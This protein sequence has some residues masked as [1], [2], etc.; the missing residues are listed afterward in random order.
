MS[1][2]QYYEFQALD[3]PLDTDAQ[4]A[5]RAISSRAQITSHS[6]VN[7]YHWGDFKGDPL[8]LLEKYF[9]LFVYWANWGTR[10]LMVRLPRRFV[11]PADLKP[12][13]IRELLTIHEAKDCTILE[14]CRQIEPLYDDLPGEESGVSTPLAALRTELLQGD[15][16]CLYLVWLLGMQEG[17]FDNQELE[18]PSP[19]GLGNPSASLH[20]FAGFFE[21]DLDLLM[22]A[23]GGSSDP[24]SRE[25]TPQAL[26]AF[27]AAMDAAERMELL[28]RAL[29]DREAHLDVELRR[30][31]VEAYGGVAAQ[32]ALPRR[33]VGELRAAALVCAEERRRNEVRRK[34]AE[35]IQ[36]AE[37][38]RRDRAKRVAT[39]AGKETEA[40][41][42][43][44]ETVVSK[45]T[46]EYPRI[47][48]LLQDLAVLASRDNACD[49]F[50]KKLNGL[51][52]RHAGKKK[53]VELLQKAGLRSVMRGTYA[54]NI[55]EHWVKSSSG[56]HGAS[57]T[58]VGY[59][60][61]RGRR[62]P[63]GTHRSREK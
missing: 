7:T 55:L 47:V 43:I 37:K 4:R 56:I 25:P 57:Y 9:D 10:R 35:R 30:R 32:T 33:T 22:A 28:C 59:S 19:P 46:S 13:C 1:E 20:A 62:S 24:I 8:E 41:S 6:L 60:R 18:P 50:W 40:W 29:V 36:R 49:A 54:P 61:K 44:E 14:F 52:V 17:R 58:V 48:E 45:R 12:Y 34:E 26:R 53:L 42:D 16:R 63:H 15:L 23:G 2:Y 11:R 5:L 27:I 31:W 38:E 39:L 3:R 21:L 51:C